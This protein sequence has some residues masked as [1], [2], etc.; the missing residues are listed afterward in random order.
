MQTEQLYSHT[1]DGKTSYYRRLSDP[2]RPAQAAGDL[3]RLI[4]S[5]GKV[6][7]LTIY[8]NIETGSIWVCYADDFTNRLTPC[9]EGTIPCHISKK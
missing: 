1:R 3:K 9:D 5:T 2:H 7:G 6:I 4:Q 8:Q